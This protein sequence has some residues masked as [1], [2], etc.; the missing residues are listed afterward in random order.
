MRHRCLA[1]RRGIV[2]AQRFA[3]LV[4]AVEAVG[5]AHAG[6]YAMFLPRRDLARDMR[7]GDVR[8]GHA[9]HV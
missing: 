1:A 2:D 8:P 9:D 3:A 4:D 5:R 7:V 6:P